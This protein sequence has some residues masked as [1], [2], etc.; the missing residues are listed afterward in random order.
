MEAKACVY[1][2][3]EGGVSS[4]YIYF[5][6]PVSV[7]RDTLSYEEVVKIRRPDT[8]EPYLLIY[9]SD[10]INEVLYNAGKLP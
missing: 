5:R 2:P 10:G 4:S 7:D 6:P 1:N 8:G 9:I 3:G